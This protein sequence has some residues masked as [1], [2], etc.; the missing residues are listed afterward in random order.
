MTMSQVARSVGVSTSTVSR[1]LNRDPRISDETARKVM[2]AVEKTGY[3]QAPPTDG[4]R[5]TALQRKGLRNSRLAVLFPDTQA[6]A[7]R[8][9]LSGRLLHGMNARAQEAGISLVVATLP[10]PRTLPDCVDL[11]Q[12]DGVIVRSGCEPW[13]NN[14][15]GNLPFLNIFEDTQAGV[16]DCVLASDRVIGKLAADFL[17]GKNRKKL[18]A[19]NSDAS[20][21]GYATRVTSFEA[22]C[23]MAEVDVETIVLRDDQ[24]IRTELIGRLQSHESDRPDGVFLPLESKHMIQAQQVL[25]SCQLTVGEEVDL[26]GC[27]HDT[28]LLE[29]I[30]PASA[31]IDIQPE[32]IGKA[33]VDQLLSRLASP[34]DA[35]R[36]VTVAPR[37]I[38]PAIA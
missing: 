23:R 17:I 15:L 1:V 8:T 28:D 37:L 27:G 7:M 25:D 24:T 30:S 22:A 18:V 29:T 32:E 33:A 31:H 35:A 36:C 14:A 26:V 2:D 21:V 5:K 3:R 16:H 4:R 19:F 6:D 20:H 10:R 12:I 34:L 13:L 11:N 9:T 38:K